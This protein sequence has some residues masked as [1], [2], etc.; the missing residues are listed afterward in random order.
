M[1]DNELKKQIIKSAQ[2]LLDKIAALQ[3]EFDTEEEKAEKAEK[4]K[5]EPSSGV[6]QWIADKKAG[7][8]TGK[9]LVKGEKPEEFNETNGFAGIT[10]PD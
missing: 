6:K 9:P 4:E 7:L 3:A 1:E 2:P 8:F 5:N 10:I